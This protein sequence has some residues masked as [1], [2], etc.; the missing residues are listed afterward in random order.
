MNAV[1]AV[2]SIKKACGH[3]QQLKTSP[4]TTPAEAETVVKGGRA[5]DPV[6]CDFQVNI[7]RDLVKKVG[8]ASEHVPERFS[9]HGWIALSGQTSGGTH[10]VRCT[11]A[12]QHRDREAGC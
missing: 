12:W 2:R 9:D 5:P 8:C 1:C 4:S 7:A 11:K 10:S 6:Q 3:I